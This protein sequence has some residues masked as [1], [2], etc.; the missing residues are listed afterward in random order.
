MLLELLTLVSLSILMSNQ[1]K[2][3]TDEY[4]GLL[5]ILKDTTLIESPKS[6]QFGLAYLSLSPNVKEHPPMIPT[7]IKFGS[8][9]KRV[10][11]ATTKS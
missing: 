8:L 7:N 6:T 9:F 5:I 11:C 3:R 4:L 2:Q 10:L 1:G